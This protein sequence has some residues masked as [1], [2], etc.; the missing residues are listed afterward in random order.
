[1]DNLIEKAEV[2]NAKMAAEDAANPTDFSKKVGYED[3]KGSLLEGKDDFF[4][5]AEAFADGRYGEVTK[6]PRVTP[7]EDAQVES[8]GPVEI[9]KPGFED[10]DGD[11]NAIVDDAIIED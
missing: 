2:E 4:S 10:L 9:T 7:I 5:K 3:T 11:G 8:D 6:V 1:M